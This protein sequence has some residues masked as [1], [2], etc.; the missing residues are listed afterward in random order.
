MRDTT[1][2]LEGLYVQDRLHIK[3]YEEETNL[4]LTLLVDRSASMAYGDGDLNK[5]D[6]SAS[7]AA[8]L[9]YLALRQK[10]ATGL[11]TFDTELRGTVPAKS[12][13][14]QLTRILSM[15]DSVGAD[16][17]TDLTRVAKQVAQG[18]PRR[19]LVLVVSDL[20]GV[21]NLAEGLRVLRQRGHDVVLFHVLHD[22]EM[23]FQF[24]G[25]T[26]FEGLENDDFN[27]TPRGREGYLEALQEFLTNT[28]T[29][30]RLS[31]EYMQVRT[32]EPLDAALAVLQPPVATKPEA[33]TLIPNS[34]HD[35]QPCFYL[36]YARFVC[37]HAAV[38]S[39]INRSVFRQRWQP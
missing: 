35:L 37:R 22:D 25:A 18:I 13:Q 34:Q 1:H 38:G 30:G 7:I 27:C 15:L 24:N 17:R 3:Q 19:G 26:R 2:R 12:N 31:I 21:D 28:R 5:F 16:G 8:C 4:R 33:L 39:L 29:C 10:D 11:Y 14:Q 23:D 20:L 9:S 32:S 6:Y 36:P